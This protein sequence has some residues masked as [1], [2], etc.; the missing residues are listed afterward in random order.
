MQN[1]CNGAVYH[2]DSLRLQHVGEQYVIPTLSSNDERG[3]FFQY[4]FE[5]SC[6]REKVVYRIT[7]IEGS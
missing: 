5:Y 4:F 3:I 1:W 7:T 2:I 6:W